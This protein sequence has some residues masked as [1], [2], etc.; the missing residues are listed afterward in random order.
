[1]CPLKMHEQRTVDDNP[2]QDQDGLKNEAWCYEC[3]QDEEPLPFA[4]SA[5]WKPAQQAIAGVLV[6]AQATIL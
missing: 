5:K 6:E 1:M 2:Y 4:D 3:D